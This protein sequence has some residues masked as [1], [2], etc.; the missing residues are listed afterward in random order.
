MLA[1]RRWRDWRPPESSEKSPEHEPPKPPKPILS[2]L[3]VP[4]VAIPE[5]DSASLGIPPDDP[6]EWR[7]C[8]RDGWILP[9][10]AIRGVPVAWAA[11]ILLSASG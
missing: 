11:C 6:A 1:S 4:T 5:K 10:C 8:S 9:V 3:S 2:V 7:H